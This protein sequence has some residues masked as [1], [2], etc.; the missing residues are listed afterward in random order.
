MTPSETFPSSAADSN[1]A[2]A[3]NF[4]LNLVLCCVPSSSS[5]DCIL[6]QLNPANTLISYVFMILLGF[7]LNS[8]S[9]P[10]KLCIHLC[11]SFTICYTYIILFNCIML[12]FV[13]EY[14]L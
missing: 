6:N 4:P 9:S 8:I 1:S 10:T 13:E 2:I 7:G 5:L 3:K 11:L 12:I 14:R